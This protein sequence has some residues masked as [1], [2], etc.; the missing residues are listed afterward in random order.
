MPADEPIADA[1]R[2]GRSVRI[3]QDGNGH[4]Y[5]ER[6]GAPAEE[7]VPRGATSDA[8]MR[9]EGYQPVVEVYPELHE[10]PP[11]PAGVKLD[12][13]YLSVRAPRG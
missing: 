6:D 7:A 8:V 3:I 1:G 4:F 10:H 5:I 2:S 11:L 13:L 12:D 9:A